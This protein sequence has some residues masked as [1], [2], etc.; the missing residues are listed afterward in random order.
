MGT[1]DRDPMSVTAA[2]TLLA[3]VAVFCL[4]AARR[5]AGVGT[6]PE[7]GVDLSVVPEPAAGRL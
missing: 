3:T 4:L 7:S 5:A 2:R 6:L 1:A